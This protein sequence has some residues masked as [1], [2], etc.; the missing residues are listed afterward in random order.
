MTTFTDKLKELSEMEDQIVDLKNYTVT[1]PYKMDTPLFYTFLK[2]LWYDKSDKYLS[3]P[4][5]LI[6]FIDVDKFVV[7]PMKPWG[8]I[9]V[10]NLREVTVEDVS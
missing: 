8:I 3:F 4:F 9:G 5:P 2:R 1:V 10:H 6:N 7:K